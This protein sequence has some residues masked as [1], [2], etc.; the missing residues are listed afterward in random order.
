MSEF[1]D[2]L[3]SVLGDP[4]QMEKIANLAKTLMGG[5]GGA[6]EPSPEPFGGGL[7]IDPSLISRIGK[8]MNN[9]GD[10]NK[11]RLL[12]AMEPYLS[13]KRRGKV[14]K[15]L[16]IARLAR[17]AKAAMGEEGGDGKL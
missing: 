6:Q 2:K 3:N 12:Q 11:Q 4:A 1:E 9:S 14:D 16:K 10:D 7:D 8:L 17:I 13:E 15:A 5:D